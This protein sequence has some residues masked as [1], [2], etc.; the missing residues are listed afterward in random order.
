VTLSLQDLL[1]V[2]DLCTINGPEMY[3][4]WK[5]TGLNP[6]A[7]INRMDILCNAAFDVG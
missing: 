4:K 1:T 5:A 2:N 6:F 3:I 7:H